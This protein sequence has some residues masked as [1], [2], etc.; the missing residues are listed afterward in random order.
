MKVFSK[1]KFFKISQ[2]TGNPVVSIYSQTSRLSTNA[3]HEDKTLFKN[4]VAAAQKDLEQADKFSKKEIDNLLKPAWDLLEDQAFWMHNTDMVAMFLHNGE[5]EILQ[6]P[7]EIDKPMYFIGERPYLIPVIPELTDDGHYYLMLIN[8]AGFKLYEATRSGIYELD[9][10]ELNTSFKDFDADSEE[11]S[12]QARS[13]GPGAMFHGQSEDSD[14]ENKKRILHYF[15]KVD[16]V[17]TPLLNKNPL[18]LFLA[19]VD[20]LIPIYRQA[21]GYNYMMDSDHVSGAFGHDEMKTLHERSWEIA[22]P[23]FEKERLARKAEFEAKNA[24]G[25]AIK[26]DKLGIVK[27]AITGMIDTLLVN[28]KHN[29]TWGRYHETTHTIELTEPNEPGSHC[30]VDLAAVQTLTNKGKVYLTDSDHIDHDAAMEATLRYP[31]S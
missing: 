25:M 31:K 24:A 19:G 12:L 13:A 7:V 8:L 23:Y 30:L 5:S 2:I 21:N 9:D 20:Y 17:F 22:A 15:H 11:K 27:A 26:I 4:T 28:Q 6:L 16:K 3:Y 10:D 29:H 14:E 18:P 1:E